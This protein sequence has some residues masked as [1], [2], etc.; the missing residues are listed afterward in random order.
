MFQSLC[1]AAG[2]AAFSCV[3]FAQ[4]GG[5]QA[6]PA[7]PKLTKVTDDIYIIENQDVTPEALRYWGGNITLQITSEGVVMVDAKYSRAHDEVVAKIKSLTDKPVKYV[8]LTHNHGDHAE[9]AAAMEAMGA[10]VIIS[11]GDRFNLLQPAVPGGKM[12]WTPEMTYIGQARLYLGGKEAQLREWRG[13]TRGDTTVYFPAAKVIVLGD[14]LTTHELMPPIVNY[15]DAGSWSEWLRSI[16][17]ILTLDWD[18][19]IPGHGPMVTKAKVLEIRNRFASILQRV[20]ELNRA[21]KTQEE[22]SAALMAEFKWAPA[23]NI[24]GMVQELR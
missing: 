17:Q 15:G 5:G 3:A 16:D 8:V 9:G 23:N 2:F 19:A 12:P 18:R 13:H 14:L 24:P 4:G 7:P 20:R 11:D 10:K 6:P 21:K 22:I 1:V